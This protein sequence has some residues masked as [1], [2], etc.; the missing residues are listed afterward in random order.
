MSN[1]Q[2]NP[3]QVP[4]LGLHFEQIGVDKPRRKTMTRRRTMTNDEWKARQK[5]IKEDVTPRREEAQGRSNRNEMPQK[6]DCQLL[7]TPVE[8]DGKHAEDGGRSAE[9]VQKHITAKCENWK[10]RAKEGTRE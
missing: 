10:K 8:D 1:L 6:D 5:K 9:E 7:F 2:A 4:I 3:H